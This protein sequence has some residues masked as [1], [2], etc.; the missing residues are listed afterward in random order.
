MVNE[1]LVVARGG[2]VVVMKLGMHLTGPQAVALAAWLVAISE[3]VP[4]GGEEAF[5]RAL[6]SVFKE[7]EP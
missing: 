3:C 1:F 6:R 2:R 7:P 4:G 5:H